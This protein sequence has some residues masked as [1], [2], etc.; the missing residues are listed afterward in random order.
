MDQFDDI[1]KLII[2]MSEY[3][4]GGKMAC[5]QIPVEDLLVFVSEEY[6][7]LALDPNEA[8]RIYRELLAGCVGRNDIEG[9][10]AVLDSLVLE[11]IT[12]KELY[13]KKEAK[14]DL[15][16][17]AI[18]WRIETFY[19]RNRE[20]IRRSGG[21]SDDKKSTDRFSGRCA[22]YTA[23]TG[24]YDS[25]RDP[26]YVD[27]SIDYYL[28]TDNDNISSDVWKIIKADNPEGLDP[29]RLARRIKIMGSW[30]YLSAHDY[31]VWIDGK[32]CI[33]G[34]IRDYISRYS[35]GS[36][37]I[38][39]NHYLTDDVYQEAENCLLLNRDLPEIINGQM[40]RYRKEGL[41][42]HSGLVD[43]CMLIRDVHDE[44]LKKTMEDWWREVRDWSKRDQL[45]FNYACWKNGLMYDTSPLV[46]FNNQYVKTYGH[47]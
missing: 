13:E 8:V 4:K 7:M 41:P 21:A 23:V 29:V 15:G 34:D 9:T 25:V 16:D 3:L 32:L 20:K 24:G 39:F 36:P 47:G 1:V 2:T 42:E 33:T 28:I 44:I 27:E 10:C 12:M 11:N 35:E 40:N 14:I 18:P 19:H 5:A 43:S 30:D 6:A 17:P 46:S 38:C 26:E 22:V 37:I 31:T 45:S